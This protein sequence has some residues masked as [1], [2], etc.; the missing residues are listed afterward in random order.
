[1]KKLDHGE[2]NCFCRDFEVE[3]PRMKITE[4][5]KKASIN[6]Q[7]LE[8]KEFKEAIKDIGKE[9]SNAKFKENK[10]RHAL[11]QKIVD[12]LEI[13]ESYEN[14]MRDKEYDK[15]VNDMLNQKMDRYVKYVES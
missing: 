7:A 3:L 4:I 15:K 2:V 10:A 13:P 11:Y 1:M 12:Q 5:F 9:Y 6:N 8:F 14:P